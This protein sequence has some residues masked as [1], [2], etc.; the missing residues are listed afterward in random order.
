M[1]DLSTVTPGVELSAG[2]IAKS[3]MTVVSFKPGEIVISVI[4]PYKTFVNG[5]R[6]LAK[7]NNPTKV[8]YTVE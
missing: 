1:L 6:L 2:V 4:N 3:G 5:I 8:T 7:T